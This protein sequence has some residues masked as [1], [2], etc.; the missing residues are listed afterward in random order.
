MLTLTELDVLIDTL[1]KAVLD[2]EAMKAA[3][4]VGDQ[5]NEGFY[6]GWLWHDM[7]MA[8]SVMDTAKKREQDNVESY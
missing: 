2:A 7:A 5:Y 1:Q 6:C 3:K 4:N 8:K